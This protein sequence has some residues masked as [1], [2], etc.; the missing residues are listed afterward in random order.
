MNTTK[1]RYPE[2]RMNDMSS[3]AKR[4]PNWSL[5]PMKKA[6]QNLLLFL[7]VLSAGVVEVHAAISWQ[8]K[9]DNNPFFDRIL[10]GLVSFN[11][12]MYLVGGAQTQ[13]G[14]V[15]YNDVWR[16]ENGADWTRLVENGAF[17]PRDGHSAFV[18]AGKIWIL[19]GSALVN[20]TTVVSN[21]VWSSPDGT[22]WT[23]ENATWAHLAGNPPFSGRQ[24][25]STVLHDGALYLIGGES[26]FN[27][28]NDI[29]RS[30]NGI[31]WVQVARHPA[32][33]VF[34]ARKYH[35]SV[36]YG[37]RLWVIG[38]DGGNNNYHEDVW[39]SATGEV[40][41]QH[42][43]FPS[44]TE[45][46]AVTAMVNAGRILLAENAGGVG[47]AFGPM[48]VRTFSIAE[49]WREIP[50][51]DSD[52]G[53]LFHSTVM[54]GGRLWSIGGHFRGAVRA[55]HD[56]RNLSLQAIN[57]SIAPNQTQYEVG[58]TVN[59]TAV[60]NPGFVFERWEGDI[61][62]TSSQLSFVIDRD[63]TVI[64]RFQGLPK[65]VSVTV[66]GRG[67][68]VPTGKPLITADGVA[69][70]VTA[71]YGSS[72]AFALVTGIRLDIPEWISVS[73]F[74]EGYEI[75][76]FMI[77]GTLRAGVLLDGQ[78][79]L[80]D[81]GG[82]GPGGSFT[83]ANI[84]ADHD[85]VV[86]YVL[87][88]VPVT[89]TVSGN[90]SVSPSGLVQ[91]PYGSDKVFTVRAEDG[92]RFKEVILNEGV[93]CANGA[94]CERRFTTLEEGK[95]KLRKVKD[96]ATLK[97]V[98]EAC[99]P[100][101]VQ[102]NHITMKVMEGANDPNPIVK[103]VV[104]GGFGDVVQTQL[105]MGA[106]SVLVD[107]KYTNCRDLTTRD[108]KPFVQS[109]GGFNFVSMHC[110]GL[111]KAAGEYFDGSSPDRPL[112][113]LPN[114][115]KRFAY[116]EFLYRNDPTFGVSAL[117]SPGAEYSAD[118]AR[119][120]PI[121]TWRFSTPSAS[122]FLP[123]GELADDFLD[124]RS[125]SEGDYF[126]TVTKDQNGSFTQSI[127][128]KLGNVVSVRKIVD[129]AE[130]ITRYATDIQGNVTQE[131]PPLGT[132][133]S[134]SMAYSA[135]NEVLASQDPDK[136]LT[137]YRYDANGRLRFLRDAR[138]R[139][140]DAGSATVNR[141]RIFDYDAHDRLV[142]IRETE[143]GNDFEAPDG[144]A[145]GPSTLK[146]EFIFDRIGAD[147]LKA[148]P[149]S[150]PDGAVDRVISESQ[151]KP[152]LIA[153]AIAYHGNGSRAT[154]DVYSYQIRESLSSRYHFSPTSIPVQK[155]AYT[156]GVDDKLASMEYSNGITGTD[157]ANDYWNN[158]DLQTYSYDAMGRLAS[159]K[160]DGANFISYAY[161]ERGL[162]TGESYYA[163]A[164]PS[165][166]DGLAYTHNIRDWVTGIGSGRAAP[167]FK[168]EVEYGGR[169]DGS[170][171]G[172]SLEYKY[173]ANEGKD[174]ELVYGYDGENRL[175]NA[176][177]N[178]TR[179]HSAYAYD[180]L[181]RLT[182]KLEDGVDYEHFG[183][184][185]GSSR[186]NSVGS[187]A[188]TSGARKEYVYDPNGNMVLDRKRKMV[189]EYDWQNLPTTMR[190]Y[191][192]IPDLELSWTDVE[193][194]KLQTQHGRTQ[195]ALFE[196]LYDAGGDRVSKEVWVSGQGRFSAYLDDYAV[197]KGQSAAGLALEYTNLLTPG[198]VKGRRNVANGK[199]YI[200][201]TD[202]LGSISAVLKDDGALDH[203]ATYQAY[204]LPYELFS[205]ADGPDERHAGKTWDS[206]GGENLYNYGARYYNP[207]IGS[208][209]SADPM[210]DFFNGY[211][212]VGGD[213]LN[214]VDPLGLVA[215][216]VNAT[217]TNPVANMP[218]GNR[219]LPNVDV[220]CG[221]ICLEQLPPPEPPQANRVQDLL[222]RG[223]RG[224][225]QTPSS[226]VTLDREDTFN[227]GGAVLDGA[228]S[229]SIGAS[230]G[231]KA[232]QGR[233]MD[234]AKA[235]VEARNNTRRHRGMKNLPKVTAKAD[236]MAKTAAKYAKA[237]KV[238]KF[239]GVGGD[240]LE[241]V[242][243]LIVTVD[244]SGRNIAKIGVVTT[245]KVVGG[246]VGGAIGASVA[247]PTIVGAVAAGVAGGY[248]GGE[249]GG[250]A[251]GQ[252]FEL[253]F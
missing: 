167:S 101:A 23:K 197:F 203:A 170:V 11:G 77:G 25:H 139:A 59:L 27:P 90:G 129:G 89:V 31:N 132:E 227:G 99:A 206:E 85:L 88:T 56:P 164:N 239:M 200:Y 162:G 83:L 216:D 74:G 247:S 72:L 150:A 248:L 250:A 229:A 157:W 176:L 153:A 12:A 144:S 70:P 111:M 16:S 241:G 102:P 64:A 196:F 130:R 58:S 127:S 243:E 237:A 47:N 15:N 168:Q 142:A 145:S 114:D 154:A 240:V 34:A 201:L 228:E 54:H 115:S 235:D 14:V 62:G 94:V 19:G 37:G 219:Q 100:A 76:K 42:P 86:E 245:G 126:L 141:F 189:I 29:W 146:A 195:V 207:D 95:F 108:A 125:E 224:T 244:H 103:H 181:G 124:A 118:P 223:N 208:W 68:V 242:V 158:E 13:G 205:S 32:S 57:G 17:S 7:L 163:T 41:T 185:P 82:A 8:T 48:R 26:D 143:G 122:S 110:G 253:I 69:H 49:G 50:E 98:F 119:G 81:G 166:T 121:K 51:L 210:D 107:G 238:L 97:F 60:P 44:N 180:G 175:I 193:G 28:R 152:G 246:L 160:Q 190:V 20:G 198:G 91:V 182:R 71:G 53:Y 184:E 202:R 22:N 194:N 226:K 116:S 214:R 147:K 65:T 123:A 251:A 159:I 183:Y 61:S 148:L 3:K 112:A 188:P 133:Y 84:T 96:P 213:P 117:G 192:G 135:R 78:P 9:V 113:G 171:T 225:K 173:N 191:D 137:E 217:K 52:G 174:I 222:S 92:Y 4:A 35:G 233:M 220:V 46:T 165:P 252:M 67:A 218:I 169:F 231:I 209:L 120:H 156:Y 105:E 21:E 178:D 30:T 2:L 128:D 40:W 104:P 186:L 66:K 80:I 151:F 18:F 199:K 179:M 249:L 55:S 106:G 93:P 136:G 39:S 212:F 5:R 43:S 24:N 221:I 172:S 6:I 232:H 140:R 161:N 10:P 73:P 38:G 36:S 155:I 204:G 63:M 138:H 236:V 79:V 187:G 211:S 230:Q 149:L 109:L 177:S 234:A 215:Q 87:Q 134:N 45:A 1:T 75:K 33:P 131:T